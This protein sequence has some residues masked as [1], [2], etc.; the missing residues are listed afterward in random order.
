MP[1]LF[2]VVYHRA[3]FLCFRSFST[4]YYMFS[5]PPIY[6]PIDFVRS[7]CANFRTILTTLWSFYFSF[8]VCFLLYFRCFSMCWFDVVSFRSPFRLDIFTV[9]LPFE[10]CH[11]CIDAVQNAN[12][13]MCECDTVALSMC[14]FHHFGWS[15]ETVSNV[16]IHLVCRMC[17]MLIASFVGQKISSLHLIFIWWC[18]CNVKNCLHLKWHSLQTNPAHLQKPDRQ[19]G[20][21]LRFAWWCGDDQ[22]NFDYAAWRSE[23]I[24]E[25]DCIISVHDQIST[26]C[27]MLMTWLSL[28]HRTH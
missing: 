12:G 22:P 21:R 26:K 18:D 3:H 2:L 11:V 7:F 15:F 8:G 28:S 13:Q 6:F 24:S 17:W 5:L 9:F 19:K 25:C 4:N 20:Q 14:Y 27:C 1:S 10:C 16:N 23:S